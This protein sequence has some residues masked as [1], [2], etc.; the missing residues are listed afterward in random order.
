M[1][2]SKMLTVMRAIRISTVVAAMLALG[3]GCTTNVA[4]SEGQQ[5]DDHTQS[6]EKGKGQALTTDPHGKA[7]SL[8]DVSGGAS[9]DPGGYPYCDQGEVFVGSARSYVGGQQAA[10]NAAREDAVSQCEAKE[11]FDRSTRQVRAFDCDPPPNGCNWQSTWYG[12]YAEFTVEG[13]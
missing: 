7:L 12:W 11:C 4:P 6:G 1:R 5:L 3:S 13:D 9:E 8:L 10:C 2:F